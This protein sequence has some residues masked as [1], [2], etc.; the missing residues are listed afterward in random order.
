MPS[1]KMRHSDLYV[2]LRCPLQM[3]SFCGDEI[4]KQ[5]AKDL[6]KSI[7]SSITVVPVKMQVT[8][9]KAERPHGALL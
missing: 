3:S 4:L 5:I 8:R 7:W 6:T 2:A 9:D 1:I